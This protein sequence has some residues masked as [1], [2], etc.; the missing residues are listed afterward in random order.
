MKKQIQIFVTMEQKK[1]TTWQIVNLKKNNQKTTKPVKVVNYNIN[2]ANSNLLA[3]MQ[4]V[5]SAQYT[6]L[7]NQ[8]TAIVDK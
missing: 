6:P 7:H 3:M 1:F 4:Y 5:H 2:A 8:S